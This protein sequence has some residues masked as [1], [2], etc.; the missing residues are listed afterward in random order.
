MVAAAAAKGGGKKKT[1]T[2][3]PVTSPTEQQ[4]FSLGYELRRLFNPS[5][6]PSECCDLHE[7]VFLCFKLNRN[8]RVSCPDDDECVDVISDLISVTDR[9]VDI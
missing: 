4:R 7:M 5:L 9:C 2:W 1:I 6:S 3:I 8:R